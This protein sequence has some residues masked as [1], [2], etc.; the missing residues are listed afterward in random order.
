MVVMGTNTIFSVVLCDIRLVNVLK[1][2]KAVTIH[3]VTL[4]QTALDEAPVKPARCRI[5]YAN[6]PKIR[7][8]TTLAILRPGVKT[9]CTPPQAMEMG[10]T[11][12]ARRR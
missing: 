2:M 7:A 9:S 12:V 1:A 10:S 8:E 3:A 4:T 11:P 5:M 6:R